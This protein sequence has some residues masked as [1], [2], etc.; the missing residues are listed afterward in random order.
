[1]QVVNRAGAGKQDLTN[2]NLILETSGGAEGYL[3]RA[4]RLIPKWSRKRG[5]RIQYLLEGDRLAL[6]MALNEDSERR[7]LEGELYVLLDA[8]R[9]AEELAGISDALTVPPN[10]EHA[11]G[12]MKSAKP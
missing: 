5:R 7:A 12:Q 2:A 4:N 1:M 8:W 3:H 11:L 9:E 10:V 6:E